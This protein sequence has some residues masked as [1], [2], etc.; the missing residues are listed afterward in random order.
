[1]KPLSS[2]TRNNIVHLISNGLSSR[3]IASKVGVGRVSVDNI[4]KQVVLEATKGGAGRPAKLSMHTKRRLVRL[5]MSGKADTATQLQQEL[6]EVDGIQVCVQTVR[7]ALKELG[8]KAVVKKKKPLLKSRHMKQRYEFAVKYQHWTEDDWARVIFSD[9]TKI[10]R[11]G[12]DG[13]KW[14]WKT[15]GRSI[16]QQYVTGTV[17]F[18]KGSLMIW[19]CMTANGV[20]WMCRIDGGMDAE[21]YTSI[22]D[23]YLFTTV[24]YYKMGR[25]DFIFQQDNDPKHRSRKAQEWIKTMKLRFWIGQHNHQTS[26]PLNIFGNT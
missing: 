19:G 4:R 1:M 22:L 8:L 23:D 26:I 15:A 2:D 24:D 7:N 20:G 18:G 25:D 5:V 9:E 12:S 17:K 10:N 6:K 16:Q 21:L 13:R 14:V 3:Q 11:L